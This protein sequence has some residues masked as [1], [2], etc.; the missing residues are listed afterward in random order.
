MP[1]QEKNNEWADR[2]A[3]QRQSG[4]S[5][6]KWCRQ[7]QIKSSVFHYWKEKLFPKSLERSHFS[8][9]KIQRNQSVCLQCSGL[10]IRLEKECDPLVRKQI[11]ALFME[12]SC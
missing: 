5:I 9:L 4:L 7:N 6:E 2:I 3:Q 10:Y 11:F 12:L 8:E 1:P